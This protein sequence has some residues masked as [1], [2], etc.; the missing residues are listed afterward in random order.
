[1]TYK[2]FNLSFLTLLLFLQLRTLGEKKQ[3]TGIC[4]T[5]LINHKDTYT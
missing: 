3:K 2:K 5:M 1:M 4:A